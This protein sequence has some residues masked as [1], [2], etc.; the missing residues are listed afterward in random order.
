MPQLPPDFDEKR[1]IGENDHFICELIRKDEVNEFKAYLNASQYSIN[2]KIE[3]SAY[4]TNTYL[5]NHTT[6]LIEYAAFCGSYDIFS[7]LKS[8]NAEF[9]SSLWYFAIH[10]AN[11]E[12]IQSIENDKSIPIDGSVLKEAIKCY[13]NDIA[14]YIIGNYF[15]PQV[16]NGLAF[17]YNSIKY[18]NFEFIKEEYLT[19]SLFNDACKY[20]HYFLVDYFLKNKK[21][22]VNFAIIFFFFGFSNDVF[23]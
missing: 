10:G 21:I 4:E 1:R 6:S 14:N 8:Q 13:Q 22:D 19:E 17:D 20:D 2:S 15:N 18:Y 3:E 16:E 11:I 5:L 7:Y 12:L 23:N 9:N